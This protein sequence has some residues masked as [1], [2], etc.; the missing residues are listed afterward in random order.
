MPEPKS[1]IK[2]TYTGKYVDVL[3]AAKSKGHV[4][5]IQHLASGGFVNMTAFVDSWND[6]F[7]SNWNREQVYGRMDPIQNFQNTQRVIS[8]GFKLVASSTAEAKR[9]LN[10]VS[11]M[12]QFLYPSY[13]DLSDGIMNGYSI[14]GA[15]I[16]SVKYMN[17]ITEPSGD[18]LVG[19]MDGVDHSFDLDAGFFEEANQVYPKAIN[20]SFTFHPLHRDTQGYLNGESLND[21]YPYVNSGYKAKEPGALD[22]Q[23]DESAPVGGLSS[24]DTPFTTID[25]DNPPLPQSLVEAN[26][27]EIL[28]SGGSFGGSGA[29]GGY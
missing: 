6:S 12:I 7:T 10:D 4:L 18:S 22:Q 21:G 23:A 8:V 17:L 13:K 2:N 19:T 27:D 20:I 3:S 14:S 16:L 29:S 28:G 1:E 25:P 26:Q 11:Q 5:R 24:P 9:N 15:P